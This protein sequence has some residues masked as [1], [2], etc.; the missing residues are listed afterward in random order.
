MRI[1][2]DEQVQLLDALGRLRHPGHG[3]AAMAHDEHRLEVI[4]LGHLLL[5]QQR[6][7][8]PPRRRN[9]GRLHHLLVDEAREHPVVIDLPYAGPMLPGAFDKAVVQ[10]QRHDIEAEV[11]GALYVGM[12]AEDIGAGAGLADVAGGEQQDAAGADV[13]GPHRVLGLAHRPDQARGLVLGEH[14]GHALELRAGY[15][16]DALD[17]LRGPL[18]DFLADVIHPVDALLDELLVLPAVLEDVP[19]QAP[20]HRNVGA[21]TQPH[22][23]GR[24]GG[25]SRETRVGDNEVRPVQFLPFEQVLQRHRVR[26]GRIA[27]EEEQRLGIADVGV[28]VGHR[29]VAPGIGYAGDGGRMTDPRLMVDIVRPPEGSEACD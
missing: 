29:A 12:A 15:A 23:F 3:V 25:R 8:E 1:G 2:D 4:G 24:M 13:G 22:I 7:I 14:L 21:W 9:A 18:L 28:A 10:R 11:G 16:A 26:L 19:E 17:L 20:K 27:A 5:G 6:R